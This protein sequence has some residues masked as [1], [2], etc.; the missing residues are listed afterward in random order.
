MSFDEYLQGLI[1][2][3]FKFSNKH[4]KR[5]RKQ[6]LALEKTARLD[7][8]NDRLTVLARAVAGRPIRIFTAEREGG[9]KNDHFFLPEYFSEFDTFEENYAYYLFRTLYLTYQQK[10]GIN[11]RPGAEANEQIA[12]A[13]ALQNAPRVLKNLFKDFPALKPVHDKLVAHFSRTAPDN[14]PDLSYVYG[15]LM[16]NNPVTEHKAGDPGERIRQAVQ[17]EIQSIKKARPVEEMRVQTVD[18]KQQEDQVLH[19]YFEKIETLE[20]HNGGI[21]HDFDGTDEMEEHAEALEEVK[22]RNV[23]RTDEETRSVYQTEFIENTAVAESEETNARKFHYTYDEW[24]YVKQQYKKDFCKLFVENPVDSNREYYKK[25]L[26]D[27]RPLLNGLRKVLANLHNRYT[28]TKRQYDGEHF[29]IDA[30]IDWHTDLLARRTPDE[31]IYIAKRTP[32]KDVSL[33]LLLDISLSSDGY[34]SGNRIIDVEKQVALLFGEIL[35]EFN[36]DFAIAAF[37]SKTRNYS[38]FVPIKSFDEQWQQATPKLAAVQPQGY[39]RIGPAIRHAGFLLENRPSKHKWLILLS[40]GK[41]NDYD[42]YEGRY[43][44]EDIKRALRELKAKNIQTYA[45]AIE[46][47]AKYYL[48]QMFGKNRYQILTSPTELLQALVKLYEIIKYHK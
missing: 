39:T 12:R 30:L 18:K 29:D 2:T 37:Y 47:Q 6:L 20:E 26:A 7:L 41:P 44:M 36:T 32:R 31:K 48:P 33:M 27:N 23:V 17:D 42:R 28:E 25:T 11:L 13:A 34:A 16:K 40:D 24:D 35:H 43:G 38:K 5:K 8:I 22:M 10:A 4:K 19:N 1:E 3:Y 15:K 45:L 46:A 9:Y 21:W 14:K